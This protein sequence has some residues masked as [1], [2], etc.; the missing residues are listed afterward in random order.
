MSQVD[1]VAPGLRRWTAWHEEWRE[2]VSSVAVD[3]DG[4]LVLIDPLDPPRGLAHSDHVLV[5][6]P[7]GT[8][9]TLAAFVPVI[10]DLLRPAEP[11]TWSDSPFL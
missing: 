8:G 9:K 5:S 6:A 10:A 7:T 1:I 11:H 4:G 3:T 2:P